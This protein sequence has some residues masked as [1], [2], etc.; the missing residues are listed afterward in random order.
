MDASSSSATTPR[1]RAGARAGAAWVEWYGTTATVALWGLL[2]PRRRVIAYRI[3]RLRDSRQ[4]LPWPDVARP[5]WWAAARG[6]RSGSAR[7]SAALLELLAADKIHPVVAERL[8]LSEARRAHELLESSA[9]KGK[10]V[11]VP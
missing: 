10:L 3:Q 1:S 11:L 2:S 4:W 8:P 5:G 6:T 7:T 9:A